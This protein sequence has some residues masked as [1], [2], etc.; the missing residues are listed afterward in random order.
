MII[1]DSAREVYGCYGYETIRAHLFD[2]LFKMLL[3]LGSFSTSTASQSVW[4]T[5]AVFVSNIQRGLLYYNL[6]KGL[7]AVTVTV[8]STKTHGNVHFLNVRAI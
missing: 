6:T 2:F 7:F 5:F 8:A 3:K 4:K 1:T